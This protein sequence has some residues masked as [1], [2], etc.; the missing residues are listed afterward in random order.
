MERGTH[1]CKKH[2]SF[3]ENF[4]LLFNKGDEKLFNNN[5]LHFKINSEL[6]SQQSL[7]TFIK[8]LGELPIQKEEQKIEISVPRKQPYI[9]EDK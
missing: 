7:A 4:K 1:Q 9:E 2:A 3:T 8:E 5:N 6:Q